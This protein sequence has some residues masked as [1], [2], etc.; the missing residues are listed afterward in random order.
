MQVL[1]DKI[2]AKKLAEKVQVPLLPGFFAEAGTEQKLFAAADALGYPLLIKAAAGG[3]GKGMK[4]IRER[5]ELPEALASAQR[6]GRAYFGDD[7]VFLEK[8]LSEP[9][10]IE[11]QILGDE[12]GHLIHLFERECSVQR[13][14]QKM[15]EESPSPS[16]GSALRQ[17]IC[18]DAVRLAREAG[19]TSAGTMEFLVDD[20]DQYYFLEA[21]TRLQ[22][23]HPVTEWVTG[24]DLVKAQFKV[25]E[26]HRL[27]LVQEDVLQR[28]HA[29]ECRLYAEDPENDFLPSDGK[30][31]VLREPL[32]PGVRLDSA[33]REGQRILPLYDPLLAKLIVY[34]ANRKEALMKMEALLQDYVF[35][36]C[37]HNL[38]FLRFLVNSPALQ[39]GRYHTH[40]VQELL[41]EFLE[42]RRAPE[43]IPPAAWVAGLLSL[44]RKMSSFPGAASAIS[45]DGVREKQQEWSRHLQN[46]RN[47]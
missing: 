31:A 47:A 9:R 18:E 38:D 2:A 30:V 19:Y 33:L 25:A 4:V 16:I 44:D 21:N 12:A 10:H 27:P 42:K 29:M 7:R 11:V 43:G 41:P 20:K 26:G 37:R 34:G 28:G 46:F 36:G 5:G 45:E 39:K 35:L 14:H 8:Y 23:E 6:E 17:K 24:V 13:R 15:I 3:G 40:T 32:R 1:G 22:V